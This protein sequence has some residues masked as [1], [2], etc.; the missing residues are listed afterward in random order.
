M[1]PLPATEA[2]LPRVL[3]RWRAELAGFPLDLANAL[4]GPL[5]LLARWIGHG[6]TSTEVEGGEPSGYH[7]LSRRGPY[8]RLVASEWLFADEL[9]EEFDRRAAMSEH[10]FLE[11][12][13]RE[14][15][16][17][18]R[19]VALL[20]PGPQQLGQPRIGQ[21]AAL[22][23][24]S[25]RARALGVGFAW[26]SLQH[27]TDTLC[28]AINASFH[29]RFL[30]AAS[31]RATTE[32]DCAAWHESLFATGDRDPQAPRDAVWMIGGSELAPWARSFE[33]SRLSFRDANS[34]E[35]EVEYAAPKRPVRRAVL[36]MPPPEVGVRLL[37][38]LATPEVPTRAALEKGPLRLALQPESG[39]SL[40]LD[41]RRLILRHAHGGIL[42]VHIPDMPK[43][44]PGKTRHFSSFDNDALVA[45]ELQGRRLLVITRTVDT[46]RVHGP[47]GTSASKFWEVPLGPE[48]TLQL[49]KVF[50]LP[51]WSNLH[52]SASKPR[53]AFV[54]DLG[55]AW[56]ASTQA[57]RPV[58]PGKRVLVH[59]VRPGFST[60]SL[61][62]EAPRSFRVVSDLFGAPREFSSG[63]VESDTPRAV[64]GCGLVA[65][66]VEASRAR[67][68]V[69]T[70]SGFNLQLNVVYGRV[71]AV[72]PS[73]ESEVG[74]LVLEQD[75][76][77]FSFISLRQSRRLFLAPERVL[78][79]A[80]CAARSIVA[81][82]T[83]SNA[84]L[85]YRLPQGD[86]LTR[87]EPESAP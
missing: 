48:T 33:A 27:R 78:S 41:G 58:E 19:L 2:P 17:D 76:R 43:Q 86:V 60:L 36:P 77:T 21:L 14:R 31:L 42:A 62:F 74:L 70:L 50:V 81:I 59:S 3:G 5:G 82:Q 65:V 7:G 20:D 51:C 63:E 12:A 30:A 23:V 53:I 37:R 24:L 22:I 6:P 71:V 4:A 49:S 85:V 39:L 83:E 8:E 72:A 1:K 73:T 79:V 66:G 87:V 34:G 46:L 32:D 38:E 52:F 67:W 13:F 54:D 35:L 68:H 55:A 28:E 40:S 80:T 18:G 29:R 69:S 25:E 57:V 47:T 84:C 64:G 10:L 44:A 15:R 45:V 11:L 61:V 9:P 75:Q 26:A 16:S 56:I